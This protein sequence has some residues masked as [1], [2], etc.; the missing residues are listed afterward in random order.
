[1]KNLR[2]V[3]L[4]AVS[5]FALSLLA[6]CGEDESGDGQPS[7]Q[8]SLVG[9]WIMQDI[10]PYDN[11]Y[12]D[13]ISFYNDGRVEGYFREGDGDMS[14]FGGTYHLD[15]PNLTIYAVWL[16]EADEDTET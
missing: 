7:A 12:V 14:H 15:D 11:E 4:L 16:D 9:T 6:A 5:L 3:F 1:M 10:T 8:N 2:N 13:R